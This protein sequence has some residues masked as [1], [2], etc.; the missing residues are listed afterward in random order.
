M[1]F[2]YAR[3]V[4]DQTLLQGLIGTEREFSVAPEVHQKNLADAHGLSVQDIELVESEVP[5]DLTGARAPLPPVKSPDD[6]LNET[7]RS[8][9]T[10]DPT[11]IRATRDVATLADVVA[12]L[13][14]S[15]SAGVSVDT[16]RIR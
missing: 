10:L 13:V 3:L 12:T 1:R 6:V 9:L 5:P 8:V 7:R 15:M 16:T 4:S 11:T 2:R 14:E